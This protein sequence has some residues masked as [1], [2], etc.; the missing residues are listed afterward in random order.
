MVLLARPGLN[1]SF[2]RHEPLWLHS[3]TPDW[4]DRRRHIWHTE[5]KEDNAWTGK[6]QGDAFCTQWGVCCPLPLQRVDFDLFSVKLMWVF[7]K[8]MPVRYLLYLQLRSLHLWSRTRCGWC[9]YCT[10][11]L[12]ASAH[13]HTQKK[14]GAAKI[15]QIRLGTFIESNSPQQWHHLP[16]NTLKQNW[17]SL[18]SDKLNVLLH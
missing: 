5:Q 14:G 8:M 17:R 7:F 18:Q 10:F 16:A 6:L 15:L 4:D 11:L 9:N 1:V 3:Y 12:T 13:K 2:H